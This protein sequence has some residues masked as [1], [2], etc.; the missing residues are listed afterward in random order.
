MFV[1][2]LHKI[3]HKRGHEQMEGQQG[4]TGEWSQWLDKVDG[5]LIPVSAGLLCML[6]L[7]QLVTSIPSVRQRVDAV[8]GR[9]VEVTP[10]LQGVQRDKPI[11]LKLYLS[12]SGEENAV[13][14]L[15]NGQY[16]LSTSGPESSIEVKAGDTIQLVETSTGT[17]YISFDTDAPN[18]L[19]PAPGYQVTLTADAPQC[20]VGPVRVLD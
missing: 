20:K 16:V 5:L 11:V 3:L 15:V 18:I 17:V 6:V 9:F 13:K 19:V 8:A 4:G 1:T 7:T 12:P 10:A 14:V 2:P